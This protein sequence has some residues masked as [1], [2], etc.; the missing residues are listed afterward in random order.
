M[1]GMYPPNGSTTTEVVELHTLDT[2]YDYII[3]N[4]TYATFTRTHTH[5][6][7]SPIFRLCPKFGEFSAE[8]WNSSVWKD[9]QNVTDAV[10]EAISKAVNFPVGKSNP[11]HVGISVTRLCTHRRGRSEPL[12]RLSADLPLPQPPLATW[13]D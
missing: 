1:L 13:D 12:L 5:L 9:H 8:F 2:M 3:A 4:P 11:T 10:L 6:T 7:K